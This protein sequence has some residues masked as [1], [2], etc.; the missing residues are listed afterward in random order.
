M[1]ITK[2][3]KIFVIP[4]A[5]LELILLLPWAS[6]RFVLVYFAWAKAA[7]AKCKASFNNFARD[8]ATQ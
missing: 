4:G 7:I 5:I 8:P 2:S 3:V 1:E 6:S